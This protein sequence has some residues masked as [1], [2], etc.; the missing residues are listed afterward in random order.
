MMENIANLKSINVMLT[1]IGTVIITEKKEHLSLHIISK[2]SNHDNIR[3]KTLHV[4][5]TFFFFLLKIL[6]YQF[7]KIDFLSQEN[8]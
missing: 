7:P 3:K 2:S 8:M 4:T 5:S 1:I 6:Q